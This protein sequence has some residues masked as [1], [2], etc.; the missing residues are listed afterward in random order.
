MK[1]S[2]IMASGDIGVRSLLGCW[3]GLR[4]NKRRKKKISRFFLSFM[5]PF[6]FLNIEFLR[7]LVFS[8]VGNGHSG[9]EEVDGETKLRQANNAMHAMIQGFTLILTAK[10]ANELDRVLGKDVQE[11]KSAG[12]P[13]P[14][15][16]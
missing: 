5:N 4:L 6:L 13:S 11:G 9:D 10:E 16:I 3:R 1:L 7:S 12:L 2:E 15:P 14:V 8:A